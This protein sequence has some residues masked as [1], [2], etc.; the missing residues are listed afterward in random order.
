MAIDLNDP[1]FRPR[2][3]D[4]IRAR[5]GSMRTWFMTE[6]AARAENARLREEVAKVEAEIEE[7]EKEG[8]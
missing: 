7:M 5:V 2:W 3:W 8:R 4:K 1:R 6:E